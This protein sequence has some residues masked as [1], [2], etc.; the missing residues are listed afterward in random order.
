VKKVVIITL[1][2]Y[3]CI[4]IQAQ[5][6]W[7]FKPGLKTYFKNN[8]YGFIGACFDSVKY[9]RN[10]QY[11]YNYSNPSAQDP[12]YD[13]VSANYASW[14]GS[15]CF[16]S[17]SILHIIN[18][19]SDTIRI[20]F[21]ASPG[22]EWTFLKEDEDT[23]IR[24]RVG[25]LTTTNTFGVEHTIKTISLAPTGYPGWESN[26]IR[27]IGPIKIS[28][29]FGL[30]TVFDFYHYP[31]WSWFASGESFELSGQGDHGEEPVSMEEMFDILPGDIIHYQWE[32][33]PAPYILRERNEIWTF[34]E[35]SYNAALDTVYFKA[36]RIMK[37]TNVPFDANDDPLPAQISYVHDTVMVSY[38]IAPSEPMQSI[39]RNDRELFSYVLSDHTR[40]R[41]RRMISTSEP[42][43][44][45]GD[46]C[47]TY[48]SGSMSRIYYYVEGLGEM[49]WESGD[50]DYISERKVVYYK[51]ESDEWGFPWSRSDLLG[52]PGSTM[53]Q[54]NIGPNP[55][56]STLKITLP[57]VPSSNIEFFIYDNAGRIL[58]VQQIKDKISTMNAA[59][60]PHG[61]YFYR[62]RMTDGSTMS[63][64]LVKGF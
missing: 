33:E 15:E 12:E 61:F 64:K 62:L 56:N 16:I 10:A 19:K 51:K 59:N 45:R 63:G 14:L 48:L 21:A 20:R 4:S 54:V 39:V 50:N 58:L 32:A 35:R 31:Y 18:V 30:H 6:Y 57:G 38:N 27:L 42:F 22:E 53:D 36:E 5:N 47:Y 1:V 41:D 17:K 55:F 9:K 25:E 8:E 13:C 46:G 34:L 23:F 3:S 7:P 43:Y 52:I 49:Y 11:Y 29:Q 37:E 40:Y 26:N 2:I 60:L 44:G 24:A 28:S